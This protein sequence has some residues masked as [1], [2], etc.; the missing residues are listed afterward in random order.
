MHIYTYVGPVVFSL[1]SC[2]YNPNSYVYTYICMYICIPVYI[3]AHIYIYIY[4]Y[5]LLAPCQ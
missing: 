2:I 4:T 5:V 3:Y 1:L